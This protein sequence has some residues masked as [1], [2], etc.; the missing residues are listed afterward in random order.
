MI[1]VSQAARDEI[2]KTVKEHGNGESVRIL[3]TGY[4]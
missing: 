1:D 3:I 4:G 2:I